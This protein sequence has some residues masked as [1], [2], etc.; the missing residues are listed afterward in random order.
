M[1]TTDRYLKIL[2]LQRGATEKEIKNAYRK[3]A[4]HFHPDRNSENGYLFPYLQSAYRAL[5]DNREQGSPDGGHHGTARHDL[6]FVKERIKKLKPR[7]A[8]RLLSVR[9]LKVTERSRQCPGCDGYGV[10]GFQCLP[11]AACQ[12]CLGTGYRLK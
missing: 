8:N 7:R 10:I 6:R 1:L 11:M 5:M 3:F 2:R 12:K 4:F 9:V